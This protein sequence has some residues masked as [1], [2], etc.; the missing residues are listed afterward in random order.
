MFLAL[1][2]VLVF[3]GKCVWLALSTPFIY[4]GKGLALVWGH[5][6]SP[7]STFSSYLRP[8]LLFLLVSPFTVVSFLANLLIKALG[9]QAV[10]CGARK[11]WWAISIPSI[12]LV[13]VT[14]AAWRSS[15]PAI[16][17]FFQ[18]FGMALAFTLKCV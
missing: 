11:L 14:A 6:R 15:Y 18:L 12:V 8:A 16:T 4:L 5:L 13:E 9:S 3:A 17:S 1:W 10:A 2:Q 7:L